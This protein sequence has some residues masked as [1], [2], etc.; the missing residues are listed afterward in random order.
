[1]KINYESYPI[2]INS[3]YQKQILKKRALRLLTGIIKQQGIQTSYNMDLN[4]I[5]IL[6]YANEENEKI[7]SDEIMLSLC[8]K[9]IDK[10]KEN[11]TI[12]IL[13]GWGSIILG[14]E[15]AV[16][17]FTEAKQSFNENKKNPTLTNSTENLPLELEMNLEQ[18]IIAAD[19][20]KMEELFH[21]IEQWLQSSSTNFEKKKSEIKDLAAILRHAGSTQFPDGNCSVNVIDITEADS[22][23]ELENAFKGFLNELIEKIIFLF[24]KENIPAIKQACLFI[25]ENYHRE[26]SLEDTARFC[27]LSTFYFSKIFKEHKKQNFINY[28]T[29]IRINEA[30]RLLKEG[31]LSMK[32]ISESI[33]YRV[34]NYFTRVFKRVLNI[35]PTDFRNNKMLKPQ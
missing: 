24:S 34:T 11:L 23:S 15:S 12:D 8:Q 17:S 26:I 32:E 4:N 2:M 13:L 20:E 10:I 5:F 35:S 19:K 30:K 3:D 27:N 33:G 9:I 31:N 21:S 18:A 6:L 7:N 29:E 1:M 14:S 16:P 28:L 22:F 25:E